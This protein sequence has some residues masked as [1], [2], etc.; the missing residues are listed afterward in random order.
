[1]T[2]AQ[3]ERRVDTL[4]KEL[5]RMKRAM[6]NGKQTTARPWWE[7]IAGGFADDAIYDEAMRLG[8]EYRRSQRPKTAKRR[9]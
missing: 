5:A 2:T 9:A 4:E 6:T 3:L 1:M 7:Q 8:G